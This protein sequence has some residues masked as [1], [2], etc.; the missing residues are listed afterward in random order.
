MAR[1]EYPLKTHNCAQPHNHLIVFAY[2]IRMRSKCLQ[3]ESEHIM[4]CSS[5][6]LSLIGVLIKHVNS[7]LMCMYMLERVLGLGSLAFILGFHSSSVP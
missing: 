3:I 6:R 1:S 5:V 4:C 2:L 7:D